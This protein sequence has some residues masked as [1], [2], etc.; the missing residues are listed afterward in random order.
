MKRYVLLFFALAMFPWMS[1]CR[2]RGMEYSQPLALASEWK[3]TSEADLPRL[4]AEGGA[5]A[6]FWQKS[7]DEYLMV[8]R[9][10]DKKDQKDKIRLNYR[11]F[12]NPEAQKALVIS[13]GTPEWIGKYRELIYD[14]Y[15]QGYSVYIFNHRGYG[16]SDRLT[17]DPLKT[18]TDDFM[19]YVHDL[20]AFVSEVVKPHGHESLYLF[21]HSF[22]GGVAAVYLKEY[23]GI[24]KAAVLSAP[25][26]EMNTKPFPELAAA[27]VS[28]GGMMIGKGDEYAPNQGAPDPSKDTAEHSGTSSQIRF[29]TYREFILKEDQDKEHPLYMGGPTNHWVFSA[30]RRTMAIRKKENASKVTDPIL[31]FS[32]NND[33]WVMSKG[34]KTFCSYAPKCKLVEIEGRHEMWNEVDSVRVPYLIELLKFYQNH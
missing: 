16:R 13:H 15:N 23:P 19:Y 9:H 1:S 5:I 14:F 18:H 4:A 6:D 24:F 12:I 31:L 7:P 27:A 2:T 30:L 26:I 34:Q 17:S 25:M 32:S 3:L 11:R 21:A 29:K 20:A 8:N 22:G 33:S 10:H 28:A